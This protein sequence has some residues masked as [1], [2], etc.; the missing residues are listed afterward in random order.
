MLS[1]KTRDLIRRSHLLAASPNGDRNKLDYWWPERCQKTTPPPPLIPTPLP[2]PLTL[3][4]FASEN[5]QEIKLH[6]SG[7]VASLSAAERDHSDGGQRTGGERRSPREEN[8]DEEIA[9]GPT[10]A[11]S[12]SKAAANAAVRTWAPRLLFPPPSSEADR[13]S[14]GTSRGVAPGVRLVAVCPGDVLT[15][16]TS[17]VSATGLDGLDRA[18]GG[19]ASLSWRVC[20]YLPPPFLEWLLSDFCAFVARRWPLNRLLCVSCVCVRVI[21]LYFSR[22]G[23]RNDSNESRASLSFDRRVAVPAKLI[24]QRGGGEG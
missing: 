10:P 17:K 20:A 13:P 16:M 18:C 2:A 23:V 15:R 1:G 19:R 21:L 8:Q 11:Y 24:F 6:M 4:R 22:N 14:I 12:L 3:P 5:N 7:F 9:F